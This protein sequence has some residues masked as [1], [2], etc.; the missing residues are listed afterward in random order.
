[1]HGGVDAPVADLG[2]LNPA[3]AGVSATLEIEA[4]SFDD[5]YDTGATFEVEAAYGLSSDAEVFG[6]VR[7][8][9]LD[10]GSVQVGGAN[11]PALN[12]TL[13]VFGQF[14]EVS[15]IG[16]EAGYRRYFGVE[17]AMRPYVAGRAGVAQVDAVN[18][19]FTVPDADITIANARFYGDS[20]V[21]TAGVD[22]GVMFPVGDRGAVGVETGVRYASSLEDDDSD[23]GGLGLASINNEGARWSVPVMVRGR[24]AF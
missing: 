5:V 18:A 17:G 9:T 3:L 2:A 1:M 10:E 20:T 24:I 15:S 12:T 8:S 4:R 7:Y 19:T 6:A 14:G 23:I 21:F 11:V 13:P 16:V 22:V